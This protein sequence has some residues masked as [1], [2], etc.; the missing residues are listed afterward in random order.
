MASTRVFTLQPN[1]HWVII[2]NFSKLPNGAA[3]YTYRSLDPSTF[4]AAYQDAAAT[5][6]YGQPIT[7]FGNGTMPPIY[8]EFD[9]A[10]PD[11]TYYIRVY[12]KENVPG[13]NSQ[14]LWDFDGISG[15]TTG[16]GGTIIVN[17]DIEDFII[18]GAFYRN[19]GSQ[20]GTPSVPAF[21]TLAPSN[22]SGFVGNL[23]DTNG[24]ASP[25]FIFA[26]NNT[27]ASDSISFTKFSPIGTADL[28]P[29]PTPVY[30]CNYTCTVGGS[31]ETYK[32]FQFPIAQGLQNLSGQTVSI[33]IYARLNSGTNNVNLNLRQFF[34]NGGSPSADVKT[35]IGGSPLGL[36]TSWQRFIINSVVVPS[37]A[38]KTLGTCG[39]D[40][41]FLQINMPLS[42][43]T[44]NVDFVL[45]SFYL[46][47]TT[48]ALDFHTYDQINAIINSPRTGDTRTTLNS[49]VPGWVLMNDGTIGNFDAGGNSNA[50]ARD[51]NDTFPLFDLIWRTFNANQ[52]LAPMYTS[53]GVPIA[54]GADSFTDFSAYR[55]I[56]LT[57]NLGRVMIGALPTDVSQAFTNTANILTV[58]STAGF[59][60]G[61]PVTVSGGSLP[62]P[63][64]AGTTYYAIVLSLTTMSLASTAALAIVG[65]AIVLTTNASGTVVMP[66]HT[67][68]SFGGNETH[69]LLA[70]ELPPGPFA[71]QIDGTV[72]N[73]GGGGSEVGIGPPG[74]TATNTNL[75]ISNGGS[76]FSIM[77]PFVGMNVFI[78]L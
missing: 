1:P 17:S 47:T 39:N 49:F 67:L 73:F 46:G 69:T 10:N 28:A 26:K 45:P 76:A 51:N 34:G 52:T 78:K 56:A 71:V 50:T 42:P 66:S 32:Y 15:A 59:I 61:A 68:G 29:N 41:L 9:S 64:V 11:D 40:A 7:G 3:I 58:T 63:L 2:D 55:Q 65:T 4:K 38:G 19:I 54:Y 14:F 31:G 35:L 72:G 37:I 30:F 44:I 23:A 16:G 48:A 5:I 77:Q 24:P 22:H 70:T 27:T 53:A 25:D 43:A 12:D 36:T 21:L 8:W 62:T 20:A 13:N 60:T 57:R 75:R 33:R 6:P 18:N 74:A